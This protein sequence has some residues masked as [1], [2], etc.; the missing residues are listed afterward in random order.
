MA[1]SI[2]DDNL[3]EIMTQPTDNPDFSE[4]IPQQISLENALQL[5]IRFH[6]AN[7][8]EYAE[9]IYRKL[10]EVAP[11][12]PNIL[13][14]FGLLRHQRG[15][16][17]EGAEW[18]SKALAIE[19][20]YVDALNNLGNIYLQIGQP[21]LA[22]PC[23]QRVIEL[24][25]NFSSAY[26]NLGIALKEKSRFH[27]AVKYLLKAIDLEPDAS[28]HYQ[29][30]GNVY[31]HLKNY[32]A[33]IGLYRK[34]LEMNPFDSDAYRK[35]CVTFYVMGEKEQ[36]IDVLKQWLEH[37]PENPTALHLYSSYTHTNIPPRA[38]DAYVRQTFDCFA[39]SFDGVLKRL[40][41]QA[42]FLVQHALEQVEPDP[43]T[44]ILLDAGCGTGLCGA[45]VRPKVKHLV[46]VD[47][48]PKMLDRAKVREVYDE[49]IEAELTEFFANANASYDGITCVDTFCYFGDL[50][51]AAQAAVNALKPN[52]WFI[53]TLEKLA[54]S[55][56]AENFHLH[57]HG[58][59]SHTEGYVRKT[60][61]DAGFRIH[62]IET[63]VLRM[64]SREPVAGMVVTA[65]LP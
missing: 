47:L 51:D 57:P 7:Q 40:E 24:N 16:A 20:D 55:D 36:C 15:Y 43:E 48:S 39:A 4:E 6:Q 18:I 34:T 25:S 9:D 64:E 56:T 21:D 63:A 3:D 49:L 12:N 59:Y 35:L 5:A 61:T 2:S 13:H 33:A 54:E 42:P 26:G 14:F 50:T 37:D 11:E 23:F 62:G 41:Y 58:R 10:L 27:E 17:E 1:A 30:L 31:R 53:F 29:N 52:G 22:E 19:P 60:L 28:H 38:S 45:L 46:G 65:Q 8:F 32:E 44:W